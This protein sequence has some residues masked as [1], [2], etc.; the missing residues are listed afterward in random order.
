MIAI[1]IWKIED[2]IS[3]KVNSGEM[4]GFVGKSG[5]GKTTIFNLLLIVIKLW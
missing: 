4:I 3:F 1:Y 5:A 2:D